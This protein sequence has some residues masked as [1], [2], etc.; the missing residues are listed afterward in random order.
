MLRI[1]FLSLAVLLSVVLSPVLGISLTG[2][3]QGAA[4]PEASPA[5]DPGA[6]GWT[7]SRGDAGHT[8]VAD[9]G[10]TGDPVEL[11]RVQADGPCGLPPA[12]VDG[13][14]YAVCGDGVLRALDAATGTERWR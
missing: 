12:V 9:A 11:W 14:V 1:R 10:P 7:N 5:A 8:G 4:T 6:G 13:V 2:G 3:A